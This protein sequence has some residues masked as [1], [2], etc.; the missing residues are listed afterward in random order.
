[1]KTCSKCGE[2]KTENQFYDHRRECKICRKS[3]NAKY[4]KAKADIWKNDYNKKIKANCVYKLVDTKTKKILLVGSTSLGVVG[5]FKKYQMAFS[6]PDD[7]EDN[8]SFYKF[9]RKVGMDRVEI[10]LIK[11]Y[12]G[13]DRDELYAMEEIHKN[14]IKPVY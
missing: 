2:S 5:R 10:N 8:K 1:M 9:W 3:R 4:Y 7:D 11:E 13:L 6:E 14:A 12:K